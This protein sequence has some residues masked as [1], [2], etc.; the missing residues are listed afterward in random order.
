MTIMEKRDLSICEDLLSRG[1]SLVASKNKTRESA[2]IRLGF[3]SL[4]ESYK[5]FKSDIYW[6]LA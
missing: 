6:S 1:D 4:I 5:N 3:N 2:F